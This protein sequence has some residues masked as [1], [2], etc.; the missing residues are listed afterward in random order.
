MDWKWATNKLNDLPFLFYFFLSV[1]RPVLQK[2]CETLKLR[3]RFWAFTGQ[4][5]FPTPSTCSSNLHPT[6]EN[7]KGTEKERHELKVS[8][9]LEQFQHQY[10]SVLNSLANFLI[11]VSP[12]LQIYQRIPLWL[13]DLFFSC[14]IHFTCFIL[15]LR[16]RIIIY[17]INIDAFTL[18]PTSSHHCYGAA[19]KWLLFFFSGKDSATFPMFS[20]HVHL[21]HYLPSVGPFSVLSYMWSKTL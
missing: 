18:T 21:L 4:T 16:D 7:C 9:H 13:L 2:K 3:P 8:E 14:S 10:L 12:A 20:V 17:N 1:L 6:A 11:T 19:C 15:G 5:P